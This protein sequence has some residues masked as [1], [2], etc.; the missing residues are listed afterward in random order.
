[1][2]WAAFAVGAGT[3]AVIFLLKRS[4]RVPGILIAVVGAT[5]IVGALDLAARA[6]VSVLGPLPQGLRHS[7]SRGSLTTISSRS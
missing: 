3:L 6:G 4:K 7:R 2:N 5:A 1:M